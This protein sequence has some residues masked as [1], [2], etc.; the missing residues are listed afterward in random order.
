MRQFDLFAGAS[1]RVHA[2]QSP[3]PDTIRGRLLCLETLRTTEEMP[4]NPWQLRSWQHVFHNMANWL[5]QDER[6]KLRQEFTKELER[7]QRP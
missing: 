1:S 6:D 2:P 3:D 7:L 5:P 4:W